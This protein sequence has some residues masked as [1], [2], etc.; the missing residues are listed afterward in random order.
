MK[1]IIPCQ[2]DEKLRDEIAKYVEV[3]KNQ[4][5]LL[6]E[7]GLTEDDFYKS[8]IFRG[9]IERVRG[10]FSATTR[11]KR[12]FVRHI[13][14][15]M[16]DE[17]FI[18]EW[19]SSGESNRHD[20]RIQLNSGRIAAIELKGCLDGNNTTIFERPANAEEF[21]IWSVCTNPGSDFGKN[22]W[23]GIHT[24]LSADIISRGY[25]VN[26]L[27]VWD[28][29]C[30]NDRPCPKVGNDTSRLTEVGPY[31]VPPPCIYVF[32]ATTPDPRS[33]PAPLAQNLRDSQLL[34]AFH[35]CFG[36]RDNEVNYVDFEVG[37]SS[38]DIRRKTIVRRDGSVVKASKLTPLRRAK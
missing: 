12:E 38:D 33:N 14:N 34:T 32:P 13:L 36:G 2:A 19:E 21:V 18:A 16:Q 20:Y 10:T 4:A 15:Y 9:A 11:G 25:R 31:R 8:G 30:A 1:E 6:G 27:I 7:H 37:F 26:G 35:E 23:S 3:L 5:H 24:R 28:M 17:G 29:L 22:V